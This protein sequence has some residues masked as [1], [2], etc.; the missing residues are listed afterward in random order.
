M[1]EI[2]QA[3]V[4]IGLLLLLHGGST[5]A[6]DRVDDLVKQEMDRQRIPGLALAVVKDRVVVKVAGYGVADRSSALPVTPET[7]FRIGSISKTMLATAAMGLVEEGRLRLDDPIAKYLDVPTTWAPI[8]ADHLLTHT[9][10]LVRDPPGVDWA[11]SQGS[12]SSIIKTAFGTPLR[13]APGA[14]WEYSNLNYIVLADAIR[15]AAGRPWHEYVT[16]RVFA[17]AAM[18]STNLFIRPASPNRARGYSDN[19]RLVDAVEWVSPPASGGFQSNVV[20]LARWDIAFRSDRLVSESTRRQMV[21]PVV[22]S[23][24]AREQAGRG[25]SLRP[26]NGRPRVWTRGGMP[27]FLSEYFHFPQADLTV[28][29]LINLDDAD[30]SRIAEAVAGLY[31][32]ASK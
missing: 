9:S 26:L 21:T 4:L 6:A 10:G 15:V 28:I 17:R 19:N 8:T 20:D 22:L 13:F 3:Y 25:F 30:A 18:S 14:R 5:R 27:G 2:R 32:P 23:N 31:L 16:D 7:I 11:L 24:G 29:V 1:P 12:E